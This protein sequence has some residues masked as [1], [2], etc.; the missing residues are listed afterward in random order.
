MAQ[1]AHR[2][3]QR[4][5]LGPRLLVAIPAGIVAIVLVW[6]G[7]VVLALGAVV[8]GVVALGE[9]Y[10]LMARV[11]PPALAGFLALAGGFV[12]ILTLQIRRRF[13]GRA[14]LLWAALYAVFVSYVVAAA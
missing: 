7:G 11:R 8:L 12:A 3:E 2:R 14:I 13:S 5:D 6:E 10:A 4:S 9:L 1:A